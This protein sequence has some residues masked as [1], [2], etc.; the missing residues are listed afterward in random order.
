MREV[1]SK[2]RDQ[3]SEIATLEIDLRKGER[4]EATGGR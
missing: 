3:I 1:R 2:A 4:Y